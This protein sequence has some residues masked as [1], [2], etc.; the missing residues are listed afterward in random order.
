MPYRIGGKGDT[1]GCSGYAVLDENGKAVGCHITRAE[2]DQHLQALYANVP[3][4]Q[5]SE[6]AG[7]NPSFTVDPKYP[8]A[9]TKYPEQGRRGGTVASGLKPKYA[10]KPKRNRLGHH[11]YSD[12]QST[13]I[14]SGGPGGSIG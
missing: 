2:A 7:A 12:E 3:D 8:G 14:A 5:K 6:I 1:A 4:A 10:K 13:G 11:S 9:G